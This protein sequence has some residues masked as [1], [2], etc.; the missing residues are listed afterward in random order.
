[1]TAVGQNLKRLLRHR[2]AGS[3]LQSLVSRAALSIRLLLR[4]FRPAAT[5]QSPRFAI[6]RYTVPSSTASEVRRENVDVQPGLV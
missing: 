4:I 3:P 6:V 2:G 5:N 1:M